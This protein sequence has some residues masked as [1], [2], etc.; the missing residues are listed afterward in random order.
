MHPTLLQLWL[1]EL[2]CL[3]QNVFMAKYN[4]TLQM[5]LR[6]NVF[7]SLMLVLFSRGFNCTATAAK[8]FHPWQN[9]WPKFFFIVKPSLDGGWKSSSGCG[10]FIHCFRQ[11]LQPPLDYAVFEA[12]LERKSWVS[13]RNNITIRRRRNPH[14]IPTPESVDQQRLPRFDWG[15]NSFVNRQPMAGWQFKGNRRLHRLNVP[16]PLLECDSSHSRETDSRLAI[17]LNLPP[18]TSHSHTPLL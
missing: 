1:V 15:V 18:N 5:W 12:L 8:L 7:K 10:S 2:C 6:H 9:L 14:F 4:N 11:H 17:S 13:Q 3:W 16:H